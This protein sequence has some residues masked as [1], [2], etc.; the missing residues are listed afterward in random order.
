MKNKFIRLASVLTLAA[1]TTLSAWAEDYTRFGIEKDIPGTCSYEATDAKDYTGRSLNIIT[2]A[3]PVIGEPTALHTA[4][5]Y[6]RSRD[7]SSGLEPQTSVRSTRPTRR[8]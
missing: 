3:I 7:T 1:S 2:H 6:A 8:F 5:T 4:R